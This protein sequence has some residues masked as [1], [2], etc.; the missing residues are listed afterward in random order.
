MKLNEEDLLAFANAELETFDLSC[1]SIDRRLAIDSLKDDIREE[2]EDLNSEATKKA[3]LN[4]YKIPSAVL[5]DFSEKIIDLGRGQKIICGIRHEGGN[6]ELPF[7]QIQPNMKMSEKELLVIYDKHCKNMFSIFQPRHLRFWCKKQIN[8]HLIGSTYLVSTNRQM[9]EISDW[10]LEHKLSF[11]NI[12]D[13]SYYEWYKGGYEEF[14]TSQSELKDRVTVNSK[15]EMQA[16]INDNLL[17]VVI[18]DG[19]KIGLIAGEKSKFL[20]QDG[21]YFNEIFITKDFKG[22]GIAK[23][24]QRKF[25]RKFTRKG[26][27]IWGTIDSQNTPSYKTAITNG[28][29]PIRFECFYSLKERS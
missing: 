11:E 1:L 10:P 18:M 8:D 22:K 7:V 26:D 28:R 29:K 21:V 23:A 3:R 4:H 27:F 25:V 14:H 9:L 20:G 19:Q 16:S 12:K 6:V 5:D 13:D 2:L 17:K 15:E 24:I